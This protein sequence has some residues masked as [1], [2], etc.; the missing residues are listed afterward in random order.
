VREWVR[1][2][3]QRRETVSALAL[4]VLASILRL[5][6]LNVFATADERRWVGRSVEFFTSLLEGNWAGTLQRGHPGVT[7]MW[8]GVVGL[9]A[10]YLSTALSEG[11][12]VD[13]GSLLEFL[14][15]VPVDVVDINYL[16]IMRLP[17]ALLT[18]MAV[19]V[20]YL[21]VKELLGSQVALLSSALLALDPFYLAH[22]RLLHHDALVTTFMTLSMLSFM[23]YVGRRRSSGYLVFSGLAAGL[24]F[25]SKS[26]SVFL[27]PFIGLLA[28]AAYLVESQA[29]TQ[30]RRG[31]ILRWAIRFAVWDLIAGAVFFLL[32]PAMWVDPGGAIERII[33]KAAESGP[34]RGPALGGSYFL[35]QSWSGLFYPVTLLYRVTPLVLGCSAIAVHYLGKGFRP[36]PSHVIPERLPPSGAP[37]LPGLRESGEVEKWDW[38]K[39]LAW[40][41]AYVFLFTLVVSIGTKK[42]DRYLLP[43]YPMLD[44]VAAV[45]LCLLVEGVSSKLKAR[46]GAQNY[47]PEVGSVGAMIGRGSSGIL[48]L[49]LAFQ[50]GFSLP[51]YPYYLSCYNP[52]VGGARMAPR[53]V[54]VGWGEGLDQ[55]AQYLNLKEDAADLRAVSEFGEGFAP[56]FVGETRPWREQSDDDIMPWYPTDYAV[57]YIGELQTNTPNEAT[58]RYFRSLEPLHTV[59]LNGIEYA[60]IYKTPEDI[61]DEVMPAQQV[62]R[63]QFGDSIL[64]LGYDLDLNDVADGE[65]GVNLYWQC[66]RAMKESH[67]VYL[68]LVNNVYHIWGQVDGIPLGGQ[69]PTNWWQE[70]MVARDPWEIEI[71]PGT[72]PGIYHIEVILYGAESQQGLEST[73]GGPLLLGPLEILRREPPPVSSLEIEHPVEAKLGDKVRLLGYNA[74]SSFRPGDNIHLNLF[75]QCLEKMQQDYTVFI[76]LVDEKGSIVAQKDNPPVDGF[77]PTMKWEPGEIVR[78][79]YDVVI[80]PNTPRGRYQLRVGMYQPNTGQR[81]TVLDL[82]GKELGDGVILSE[83][84]IR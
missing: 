20:I 4:F 78:D 25:L 79:Q 37:Q 57:L 46:S 67:L 22:S 3:G 68:K 77:Y 16:A 18:S 72:P 35:G 26:T 84:D 6:A 9:M 70:G 42:A 17:T 62:R 65:I 75:W 27:V 53:I 56:F 40:L 47:P 64:F 23:V 69:L 58:V 7:T 44:I 31:V 71:L 59:R 66:L 45:G 34:F 49:A 81:L 8:S 50:A 55:A 63:V 38:E 28:L 36:R 15:R 73:E 33:T 11:L 12:T 43:V 19:V 10:K 24:A 82:E 2:R 51:G 29:T 52:L 41:L 14:V 21:L 61:P 54:P 48:A 32:W 30:V 1:T 60:W 83:I 13:V 74:E 5:P 76:H 39:N 80:A